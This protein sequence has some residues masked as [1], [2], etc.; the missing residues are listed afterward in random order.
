[1][2]AL[3]VSSAARPVGAE[4]SR[5]RTLVVTDVGGLSADEQLM[6]TALQGIA[7]RTAPSVYL[8]GLHNGQDF[9]VDVTAEKWLR[10]AVPL[11]T[12]RAAPYNVLREFR[13]KVRGLVI[14]DPR[15]AVDTQNIATTMAGLHDWLPV[16]PA[17]A[18]RLSARFDLR[19]VDD[20]RER[21][22]V[23]RA[24]AYE[25]ALTHLPLDRITHL[26]WLGDTR[27]GR[28]GHTLR[29]WIVARRGFA[30]EGDP[31]NDW[32]IVLRILDAFPRGMQVFGYPFFDTDFYRYTG[33]AENEGF[34]VGE[35][36]RSGK[37][38]VPTADASNLTV[39]SSFA[40]ARRRPPWDDTPAKPAL[41]TT[42]VAFLI[43]DGDNLGYNLQALRTRHWEDPARRRTT[44]PVGVS[45]SP[46]LAQYA[47]RVYDFYLRTRTPREVFVNGPSGAGYIYPQFH[48]D[49]GGFLVESKR[50]LDLSGLRAVWVLDNSYLASPSPVV[51]QQYADA[52]HPSAL[53][54]DYGGYAVTN[55]PPVTFAGDVPVVRALWAPDVSSTVER[56]RAT[57]ASYPGRPAFVLVALS[58]WTMGLSQAEAVMRDLGPGFTAVRPDRLIGLVRGARLAARA[59]AELQ[60]GK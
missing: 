34:G 33:L 14:W 20:L 51:L 16:S 10:D 37:Q 23:S 25:W 42:Y 53:F 59:D 41:D 46:R 32:Q 49:L 29:D 18:A 44:I 4:Q 48:S 31:K 50:L 38:L 6:F 47:P 7:N 15:L 21:T 17:L 1:M 2:A 30:F 24:S 27:N 56:V 52:L 55:P 58:T 36:S 60:P 22:F 57:A 9:V 28:A 40:P 5:S 13:S 43:S 26:A 8:T 3:D 19:V 45:I 39:H 11:P 35:I 54:A 12:R